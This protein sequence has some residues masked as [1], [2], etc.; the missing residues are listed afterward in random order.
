MRSTTTA[1][2]TIRNT[3]N[4]DDWRQVLRLHRTTAMQIGMPV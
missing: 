1:G 3:L 2:L 4:S